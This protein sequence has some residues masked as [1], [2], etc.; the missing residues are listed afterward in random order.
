M[1]IGIDVGGTNLVAA[2]IAE[3]GRILQK[4][5]RPV[6]RPCTAEMLCDQIYLLARTV[7][8]GI[9]DI[10]AVGIGFPGLVDQRSGAV[11]QTPNMPFQGT[12]FRALFQKKW[13][14]P[15]FMGNDADCAAIGEYWS[16]AAHG[17][18]PALIITLGT[19]IGG[20]LISRGKLFT[21]YPNGSM[22][23]GHMV[24]DPDGPLCGCGS[25]G[26][27]EQFGSATALIRAAKSRMESA[28]DS[29]LW[30]LCGGIPDQL[31]GAAVFQA[32]GMADPAAMEVLDTYTS[33]LAIG[34]SNLINILKPEIICLGGGIS[35]AADSLLLNPLREKVHR[36]TFDKGA[37]VRLERAALGN[38]AG[39][40]G[41]AMLCR[42]L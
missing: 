1:L 34:I 24:I 16:G 28:P 15:V 11:L 25:R 21:G 13:N 26:C 32:A 29:I 12:P 36:R 3:D 5:S 19:G 9:D 39:L 40:I 10:E 33:W 30:T 22:E 37:H 18:D 20:G 2:V 35:H 27:F 31:K 41:A 6:D 38:D 14:V 4:K 42:M 7:S 8:E 23:I 17:C